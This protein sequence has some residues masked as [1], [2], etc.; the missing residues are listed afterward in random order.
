[1]QRRT[2][3]PPSSTMRLARFTIPHNFKA[4]D[5]VRWHHFPFLILHIPPLSMEN[6]PA[7]LKGNNSSS[8]HQPASFWQAVLSLNARSWEIFLVSRH[9]YLTCRRSDFS[10]PARAGPP[11]TTYT[12]GWNDTFPPMFKQSLPCLF[13]PIWIRFGSALY[14]YSSGTSPPPP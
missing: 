4:R 13:A 14:L 3:D 10:P 8:P 1:M 7:P 11:T 5:E 12:C 6:D 9:L 2:C